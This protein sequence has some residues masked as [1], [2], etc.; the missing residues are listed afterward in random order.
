MVHLARSTNPVSDALRFLA[1]YQA[2]ELGSAASLVLVA[3]GYGGRIPQELAETIARLGAGVVEVPDSGFDLTAYRIAAGQ[4]TSAHVCFINSF[5]VIR[6]DGWLG[7]LAAPVL[8]GRAAIS[9]ATGSNESASSWLG[10]SLRVELAG[11]H[12]SARARRLLGAAPTAVRLWRRTPRFP[13][14]H[15]RSNAFVMP[16][17]DFLRLCPELL[18]DKGAAESLES[19]RCGLTR[20]L[21]AEG[22]GAVVVGRDGL[23]YPGE[24]W[25]ESGTFRSG[26]QANLLVSDNRTEQYQHADEQTKAV[27]RRMAWGSADGPATSYIS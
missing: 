20:R 11:A 17:I 15:I 1:S 23:T 14:P 13:N 7:K 19:G 2:H 6:D 10:H 22:G 16:R 12:P 18:V 27:L 8:S 21:L 4:L 9:G 5:S 24:R 26:N 3:K 25:Y